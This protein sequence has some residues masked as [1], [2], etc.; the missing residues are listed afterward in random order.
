MGEKAERL[1]YEAKSRGDEK[2]ISYANDL[3][4]QAIDILELTDPQTD[5][6][7]YYLELYRDTVF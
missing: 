1:I 4:K 5:D 2:M 6:S 7:K 3:L